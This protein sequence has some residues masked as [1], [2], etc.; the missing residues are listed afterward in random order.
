M[1]SIGKVVGE[2]EGLNAIGIALLVGQLHADAVIPVFFDLE[3]VSCIEVLASKASLAEEFD[4]GLLCHENGPGSEIIVAETEERLD[5]ANIHLI[6]IRDPWPVVAVVVRKDGSRAR[7][8]ASGG[9]QIGSA[10]ND[11]VGE[12]F[13]DIEIGFLLASVSFVQQAL[14]GPLGDL[15]LGVVLRIDGAIAKFGLHL[16]SALVG[17]H[18]GVGEV[19]PVLMQE[20]VANVFLAVAPDIWVEAEVVVA[21]L[22]DKVRVVVERAHVVGVVAGAVIDIL[23]RCVDCKDCGNCEDLIVHLFY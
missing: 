10:E 4:V 15:G 19:T 1:R 3:S 16:R 8:H 2:V 18:I 20:G 13:V 9:R 12:V 23:S 17:L 7:L 21:A 22:L 5:L 14:A 11:T 6:H